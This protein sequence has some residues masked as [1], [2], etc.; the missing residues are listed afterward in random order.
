MAQGRGDCLAWMSVLDQ[1]EQVVRPYG[2]AATERVSRVPSFREG[3]G[4]RGC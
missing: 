4:F 3:E 2:F 1:M